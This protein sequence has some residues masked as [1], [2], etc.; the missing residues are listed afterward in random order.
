MQK[1][2]RDKRLQFNNVRKLRVGVVA[3]YADRR[4]SSF[5]F[6]ILLASEEIAKPIYILPLLPSHPLVFKHCARWASLLESESFKEVF[7]SP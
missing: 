1:G 7:T 4:I 2:D 6:E 5:A 3:D